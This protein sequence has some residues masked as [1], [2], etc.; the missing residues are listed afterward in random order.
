MADKKIQTT[1]QDA[2]NMKDTDDAVSKK[3]KSEKP[4]TSVSESTDENMIDDGPY[5]FWR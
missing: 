5:I 1:V 3:E 4:N 2:A